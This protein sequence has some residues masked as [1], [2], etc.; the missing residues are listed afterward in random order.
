MSV[1]GLYSYA[2]YT[3]Y[4]ELICV[5]VSLTLSANV[6]LCYCV[7]NTKCHGLDSVL[8]SLKLGVKCW[9]MFLSQN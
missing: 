4:K 3:G 2:S 5:L 6:G 9:S 8:V 7:T 1:D